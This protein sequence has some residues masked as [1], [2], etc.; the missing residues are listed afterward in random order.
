MRSAISKISS[1]SWLITSTAAPASARSDSTWRINA[2]APASTPQVGWLITSTRGSRSSSRPTTNFCR[3]P[4]DSADA[5]GFA[6]LARTSNRSVTRAAGGA[7]VGAVDEAGAHHARVG[8]VARKQR[9]LGQHEAGHRAMAEPLLRHEGGSEPP[10][11]GHAAGAAV[12]AGDDHRVPRRV[13]FAGQ[14]LEQLRLAVAGHPRRLPPPRRRAPPG[15]T[16]RSATPNGPC[17][18]SDRPATGEKR[19]AALDVT[20]GVYLVHVGSHHQARQ[21]GGGLHL[22]VDLGHHLAVAQDGSVVA[23]LLHLFQPVRDVQH[24]AAV[25]GQPAQGHEQLVR[26]LRR[27]HRGRLVHDQ[28]P[29]LLQQAAHDLDALP[30]T[31]RQVGHQRGGLQRQAVFARHAGDALAEGAGIECTAHGEGRCSPPP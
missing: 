21:R 24:R 16:L 1:R 25:A 20:G 22:W 8:G 26:L 19:L 13:T 31:D 4:P 29:R 10:S 30:F 11:C 6:W 12:L 14:G 23:Q 3:L 5:A 2:A 18:G 9:V 28:Q 27:Q 7:G 15:D 17:A